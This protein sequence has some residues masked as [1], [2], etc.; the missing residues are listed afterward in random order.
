MSSSFPSTIQPDVPGFR[1]SFS[2]YQLSSFLHSFVCS[3]RTRH[4]FPRGFIGAVVPCRRLTLWRFSFPSISLR[5]SFFYC[6]NKWIQWIVFSALCSAMSLIDSFLNQQAV[7]L[8]TELS[9]CIRVILGAALYFV[10]EVIGT[11]SP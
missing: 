6:V 7:I 11:C 9:G 2:P 3:I 8:V 5:V 4:L 10:F 1:H